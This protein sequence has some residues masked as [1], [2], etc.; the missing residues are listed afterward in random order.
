MH[1]NQFLLEVNIAVNIYGLRSS[2][3]AKKEA[4]FQ[5]SFCHNE[6]FVSRRNLRFLLL[7]ALSVFPCRLK[8]DLYSIIGRAVY[9]GLEYQ[10]SPLHTIYREATMEIDKWSSRVK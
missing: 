7:A 2:A 6:S 1:P 8:D 3:H 9:R 10:F 5:P 4:H